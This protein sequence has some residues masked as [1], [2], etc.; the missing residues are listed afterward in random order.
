[1]ELIKP[2][3]INFLYLLHVTLE[4]ERLK[5]SHKSSLQIYSIIV[6]KMYIINHSPCL[7]GT[8]Q[9][10]IAFALQQ[11]SF[12][13][14]ISQSHLTIKTVQQR[15]ELPGEAVKLPSLEALRSQ[16][17][18]QPWLLGCWSYL[19]AEGWTRWLFKLSSQPHFLGLCDVIP[20]TSPSILHSW[21]PKIKEQYRN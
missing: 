18:E 4:P 5:G 12:P 20:T 6:V 10:V 21:A 15:N 7:P 9:G 11:G 2:L 19:M 3:V 13:L 16:L 1:M 14:S 8:T 17:A